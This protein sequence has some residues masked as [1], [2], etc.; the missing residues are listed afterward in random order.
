G[1]VPWRDHGF[2]LEF[3]PDGLAPAAGEPP[4]RAF[5][6]GVSPG[7]FATLGLPMIEG[8]DFNDAD[9]NSN[10]PVAIVSLTLAA[11][12]FPNGTALGHYVVWT[13]PMLKFAGGGFGPTRLRII[14]I[15]PD[16]DTENL[17]G[18]PTMT[19]YTALGANQFGGRLLVH[20]RSN[21]YTLVQPVISIM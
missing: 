20:S 13:D 15:V 18:Q 17:V 2:S 1:V 14:G 7:F 10:D 11:R 4:S 19:A 3:S 9:G 6:H 5:I 8:R 16:I 12:I 21:P